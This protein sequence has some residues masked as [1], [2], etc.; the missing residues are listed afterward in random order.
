MFA[1]L[2]GGFVL[3]SSAQ[4]QS[5]GFDEWV[6]TFNRTYADE[7]EKSMRRN[8]FHDNLD[9]IN[10]ENAKGRPYTVGLTEFTDLTWDEFSAAHLGFD[11]QTHSAGGRVFEALDSFV[12]PDAVDWTTEGA[13]TP[14][15]NQ[16][17]C[18]SCWSFS[19]TGALEGAWKIAGHDLPSLSEQMILDCDT[20]GNKCRG[21]SMAQAFEWVKENG[22]CAESDDAYKCADQSSSECT[23]STCSASSGSCSKVIQAGDVTGYTQVSQSEGALEA[24]VAQQP[25]S[26]AIEADQ[27]VFQHYTGGVLTSSACGSNLD[28]GVL[29]VGYGTDNG[30]KYWKVKNSWGSSWGESGYIRLA[31]GA[32]STGGECGIRMGAVFPTLKAADVPLIV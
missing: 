15:K 12:E 6:K 1:K 30:Q 9:W 26:V 25:V 18:G 7:A 22:L 5:H 16:A 11:A 8:I 19:T 24:A 29:A 17:H 21:G 10:T 13:V 28:H 23:A 20:G 2:A 27:Q 14:V 32:S 31:K 3:V 4:A